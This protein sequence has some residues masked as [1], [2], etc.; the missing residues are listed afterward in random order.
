MQL[1]DQ[2]PGYS[3][4]QAAPSKLRTIAMEFGEKNRLMI[5]YEQIESI[6][7]ALDEEYVVEN[8]WTAV[9]ERLKTLIPALK[10]AK[11][12]DEN[13]EEGE[14]ELT[15]EEM[16]S[17]KLNVKQVGLSLFSCFIPHV[18]SSRNTSIYS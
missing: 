14:E 3:A 1:N 6:A 16:R 18:A 4:N 2:S 7:K 8:G 17:D 5:D 12:E 15:G 13:M 10:E 9:K 11:T